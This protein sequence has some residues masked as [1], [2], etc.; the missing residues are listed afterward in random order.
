M[1]SGVSKNYRSIRIINFYYACQFE[2]FD[3]F[4]GPTQ[5]QC[6]EEVINWVGF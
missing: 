6:K 5:Q 1:K 2:L 4:Y 3:F